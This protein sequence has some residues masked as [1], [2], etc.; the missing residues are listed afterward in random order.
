MGPGRGAPATGKMATGAGTFA[1]GR[2]WFAAFFFF[3]LFDDALPTA[4]VLNRLLAQ[5]TH[6]IRFFPE[7]SESKLVHFVPV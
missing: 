1:P 2:T 5:E 7:V 3:F 6:G 4:V